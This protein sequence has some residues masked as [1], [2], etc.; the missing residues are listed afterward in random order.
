MNEIFNQKIGSNN[1]ISASITYDELYEFTVEDSIVPDQK[2]SHYTDLILFCSPIPDD[3]TRQYS[4][5]PQFIDAFVEFV[6]ESEKTYT[7]ETTVQALNKLTLEITR[8]DEENYEIEPKQDT[9]IT[10]FCLEYIQNHQISDFYVCMLQSGL[11]QL[12]FQI[13]SSSEYRMDTDK[14]RPNKNPDSSSPDAITP[15]PSSENAFEELSEFEELDSEE[16]INAMDKVTPP[17]IATYE[18]YS[19]FIRRVI[20]YILGEG[21]NDR[22]TSKTAVLHE[23]ERFFNDPV[24]EETLTR[25]SAILQ[26]YEIEYSLVLYY[27]FQF[28]AHYD[29]SEPY[30]VEWLNIDDD[31]EDDGDE[32]RVA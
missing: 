5:Y 29:D 18:A 10:S 17:T 31:D 11:N 23:F 3:F 27:H 6:I 2:K 7:V 13:R 9:E 20:T 26:E 28:F 15:D 4:N 1:T 30:E 32:F 16:L 22:F 25:F 12:D 24:G 14:F 21:D 19:Q 8:M